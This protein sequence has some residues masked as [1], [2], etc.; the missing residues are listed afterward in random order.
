[1]HLRA[2]RPAED[3]V[4]LPCVDLALEARARGRATFGTDRLVIGTGFGQ[5]A[6]APAMRRPINFLVLVRR[7]VLRKGRYE[8]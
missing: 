8:H 1:M 4:A 7:S 6:V 5:C 2:W 3:C